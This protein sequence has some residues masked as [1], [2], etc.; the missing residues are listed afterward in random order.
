[1]I[2]PKKKYF[3]TAKCKNGDFQR[4]KEV[5]VEPENLMPAKLQF[6]KEVASVH[7]KHPDLNNFEVTHKEI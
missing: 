1:M 5:E 7:R 2:S 6:T 3:L 4:T